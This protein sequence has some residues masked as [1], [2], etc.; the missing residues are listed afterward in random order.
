MKK[1][2][3]VI[4]LIIFVSGFYFLLQNSKENETQ[5][6]NQVQEMIPNINKN[7]N[8][9]I[10]IIKQGTGKETKNGDTIAVHYTGFLE[11]GT[12]FDSS[13]D[14]GQPF[15][16]TLGVGQV[17]KGWD[18]GILGMK[19]GEERKLVIPSELGYGET[20]TP[21]GPIPPNATLIFEVK[22]LSINK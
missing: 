14:R 18:L 13:L 5:E 9:Q 15:V 19:V 2:I 11:N 6:I 22:L 7:Q 3:L 20:G 12:K 1:I 21:G 10:E 8:L 17:I 16:F 4:L